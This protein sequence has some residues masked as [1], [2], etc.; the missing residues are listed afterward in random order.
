M[1]QFTIRSIVVF[2]TLL[3][4]Y[5]VM[6]THLPEAAVIPFLGPGVVSGVFLPFAFCQLLLLITD[7]AERTLMSVRLQ[8]CLWCIFIGLFAFCPFISLWIVRLDL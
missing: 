5:V 3:M 6:L 4:A 8:N 1:P 7:P 2:T